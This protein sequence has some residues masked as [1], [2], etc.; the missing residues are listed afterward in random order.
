MLHPRPVWGRQ[1][2]AAAVILEATIQ[3][4]AFDKRI[5]IRYA[6]EW[7]G[8]MMS[9]TSFARFYQTLLSITF[10]QF[11]FRGGGDVSLLSVDHLAS[12]LTGRWSDML[13]G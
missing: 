1:S 8:R 5:S 2:E 13:S 9:S 12:I 7:H 3:I 4:S 10:V 6:Y 11:T